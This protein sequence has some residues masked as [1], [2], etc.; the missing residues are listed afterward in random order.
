MLDNVIVFLGLLL[1]DT[2]P[3]DGFREEA[4]T[5]VEDREL[6]C[7]HFDETVVYAV[8]IQRGHCM[9][10]G[11]D[12]YFSFGDYGTAFSLADMLGQRIDDRSVFQIDTF[13]FVTMVFRCRMECNVNVQSGVQ[14]FS[15]QGEGGSKRCLFMHMTFYYFFIY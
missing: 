11:A 8:C 1:L 14:P 3:L 10:N 5:T 6:R 12:L 15:F 4:G 13:D 9:F 2:H 7:I